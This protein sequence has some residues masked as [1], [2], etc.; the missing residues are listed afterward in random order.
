M[1]AFKRPREDAFGF[2]FNDRGEGEGGGRGGGGRGGGG[3]GG[4]R[5]GRGGRGGGQPPPLEPLP[6]PALALPIEALRRQI[7][8]AVE[9]HAVTII[10][11]ETGSGKTTQVPL[12]L[13]RAGWTAG[14]RAVACTQPRR[15]AA[16]A[17]AARV[18]EEVGCPLGG[19]VGYAVRFE[20]V[21]TPA[22]AAA[23]L[24][25]LLLPGRGVFGA[26]V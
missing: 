2:A 5:G 15:V 17:V 19:L 12:F 20:D 6:P 10:V 9:G 4:G 7:L 21:T 11:G 16:S 3:R 8:Y 18:A 25:L 14:G 22:R 1:A 23:C 26:A 24:L 13:H